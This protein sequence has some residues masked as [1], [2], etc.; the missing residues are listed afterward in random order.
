MQCNSSN[1]S[2]TVEEEESTG[3]EAV[4]F[5][6]QGL[7]NPSEEFV[8]NWNQLVSTISEDEETI[9][10]FSMNPDNVKWTS[11]TKEVLYYSFGDSGEQT[12]INNVFVMNIFITDDI[13][14]RIE[15]F[16]P[17]SK[18]EANAQQTKLFFLLILTLSDETLDKD[19]REAILTNLGLYD[20]V[21]DPKQLAGSVTKNGVQYILEPL[22]ENNF[23]FGLSLYASFADTSGTN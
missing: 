19:G 16:A 20:N 17:T 5:N 13:V 3:E 2:E 8:S 7:G 9:L 18:D 6:Y 22:V 10:Y 12:D 21:S 15:F 11:E 14:S 1:E 4:T 23:L